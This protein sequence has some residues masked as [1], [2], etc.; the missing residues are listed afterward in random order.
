MSPTTTTV[1]RSHALFNIAGG[2]W[3]LLHRP[4]FER[5]FGPK[6][7]YWLAQTVAALLLANG[8][9]QFTAGRTSPRHARRLGIATSIALLGIDLAYVPRGRIRWTYLLDAVAEAGWIIVWV[10]T[11]PT[12]P[13]PRDSP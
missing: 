6:Q 10:T 12:D 2:L 4:S 9:T 13:P 3:P 11:T 5:V 7:D 1:A 8:T